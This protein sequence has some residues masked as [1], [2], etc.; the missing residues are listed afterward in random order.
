[1][2][3]ERICFFVNWIFSLPQEIRMAT[4]RQH[5]EEEE[6]K[7]KIEHSCEWESCGMPATFK[8]VDVRFVLAYEKDDFQYTVDMLE[9]GRIAPMAMVTERV[10]LEEV[11]TTFERLAHSRE[12]CKVLI[13]PGIS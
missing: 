12:D 11:P 8:E 2:R 13:H 6:G 3:E 5:E 1:M 4:K 9:Q 7:K 10:A